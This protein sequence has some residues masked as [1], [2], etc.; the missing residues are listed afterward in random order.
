MTKIDCSITENYFKEK[1]RMTQVND[2]GCC[3]ITCCDCPLSYYRNGT[4]RGCDSYERTFPKEAIAIVQK[5]SDE[6]P[7]KTIL[8]DFLEK[9][10]KANLRPNGTFPYLCPYSLGYEEAAYCGGQEF[11]DCRKCWSRPLEAE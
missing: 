6:H 5:W 3:S 2:K 11:K 1:T 9:Y 4:D 8:D 7:I 10:P